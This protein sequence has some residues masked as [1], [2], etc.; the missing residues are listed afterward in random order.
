MFTTSIPETINNSKVVRIK[1]YLLRKG[2]DMV[3]GEE[4]EIALPASNVLQFFLEGGS[5]ISVRPSGTE[6][7]IK[8]YFSVKEKLSSKEECDKVN[9]LLDKK[10]EHIINDLGLGS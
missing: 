9:A 8:Y 10:I 1:D 5:K 6:P 7:K 2:K 3:K 4:K